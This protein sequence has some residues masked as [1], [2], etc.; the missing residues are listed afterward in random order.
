MFGTN[1]GPILRQDYHY[2]QND[3]NELLVEPRD[4]GVPSGVSKTISDPLV[5]LFTNPALTQTTSPNG[6]KRDST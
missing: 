1:R 6:P 3:R 5:C 4:L 2:P